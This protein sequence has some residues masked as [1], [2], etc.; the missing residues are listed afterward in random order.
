MRNAKPVQFHRGGTSLFSFIFQPWPS[1]WFWYVGCTFQCLRQ[2]NILISFCK[3][4]FSFAFASSSAVFS[5]FGLGGFLGSFSF[6]VADL[7][8]PPFRSLAELSIISEMAFFPFSDFTTPL[9]RVRV[10][11]RVRSVPVMVVA[12]KRLQSTEPCLWI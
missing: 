4:F 2:R 6:S 9:A 11:P 8:T 7:A 12:S 10:P 1:M 3:S 5:F